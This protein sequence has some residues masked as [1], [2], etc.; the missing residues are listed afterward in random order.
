MSYIQS[1]SDFYEKC[2]DLLGT[3][4]DC[5][6]FPWHK[7]TRWNNRVPGSG[8]Y[9]GYG[10]IRKFGSKIHVALQKPVSHHGI[11]DSEKEVLQFLQDLNIKR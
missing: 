2:A 4:Y 7:R 6:P 5:Q 3:E 11:Y 9:P 1:M 8:R 10:I